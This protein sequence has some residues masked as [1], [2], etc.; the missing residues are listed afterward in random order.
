MD[1]AEDFNPESVPVMCTLT[2]KTAA[3]QVLEWADLQP[4]AIDITQLEGG[5][6]MTFPWAMLG[7]VESLAQR[8]RACCAFL[9]ITTS[10]EAD[11]LTLEVTSDNTDALPVISA[12]AGI[13]L[14]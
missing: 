1:T 11:V 8:E 12:L 2:D 14:P 4:L 6:R 5:V 9:T 3:A 7:E 13:P 10:V